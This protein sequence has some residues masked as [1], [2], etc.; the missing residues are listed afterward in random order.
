VLIQ[1]DDT[2]WRG[3]RPVDFAATKARFASTISLEGLAEDER[4]TVELFPVRVISHPISFWQIYF[5]GI[6]QDDLRVILGLIARAPRPVLV[7]CQHGEDRTGLV[8]AAYRVTTLGW[9]YRAAWN[10]ALGYGYRDLINF[11]L[12][13]TW[14]KF[15]AQ[16]S[17]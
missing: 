12:N 10:E 6:S 16:K 9:D 1:V 2:L 15:N 5:T 17:L 14:K 7:H 11:G 13:R 8:I 4:E 3:S